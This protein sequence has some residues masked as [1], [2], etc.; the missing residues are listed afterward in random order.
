MPLM[1][2][3]SEFKQVAAGTYYAVIQSIAPK[4][5]PDGKGGETS[6]AEWKFTIG[7][8]GPHYGDTAERFTS[9]AWSPR[10]TCF[11]WATALLGYAPDPEEPID[12]E[13]FVGH[14]CYIIV[15]QDP[16]KPERTKVTSLQRVIRE[17]P[18]PPPPPRPAQTPQPQAAPAQAR[19]AQAA[20][21]AKG[22]G[23]AATVAPPSPAAPAEPPEDAD[24]DIEDI[25]F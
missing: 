17:T 16:N 3:K 4:T 8:D 9:L 25:D 12:I 19:P 14:E 24:P 1:T 15:A 6:G 11:Q 13:Q 21:A 20:T 2:H 23:K 5:I 7:S 10:S 22:K 18:P